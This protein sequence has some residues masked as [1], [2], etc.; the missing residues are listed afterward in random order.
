[1][2][3]ALVRVAVLAVV[4]IALGVAALLVDV[5][6]LGELRGWIDSLG[7]LAAVSFVL[8]YAA[9]VLL[10]VPKSVLT[11]A[12][13][14][15]FGIPLGIALV[16]TAATA[17][18][19]GAFGLARLLGRDAFSRLADGHLDRLEALLD[20][21]GMLAALVVRLIPVMPFTPLNYAC[22][23]TTMRLRHYVV[24][25]ALGLVP[26]TSLLVALGSV[27]TRLSPWVLI[28]ISAGLATLSIGSGYLRYRHR[29]SH[30]GA[31][32]D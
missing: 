11:A 15:A 27:G 29:G 26:G 28:G 31:V 16:L 25:T 30:A 21:H 20:R 19:I 1:M 3:S 7:P 17:G 5:P 10:P 18:A 8:I 32:A 13:G 6:G 24:G 9:A 2:R 12:A 22:G 14:L 23:V 4:L